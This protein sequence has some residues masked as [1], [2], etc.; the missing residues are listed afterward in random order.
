MGIWQQRTVVCGRQEIKEVSPM[1][2]QLTMYR[3]GLGDAGKD[4][5]SPCAEEMELESRV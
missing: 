4:Q 5:G 2:A 3:A 1:T